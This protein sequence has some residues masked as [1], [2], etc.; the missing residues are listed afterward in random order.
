MSTVK[1]D[2]KR[3]QIGCCHEFADAISLNDL[4]VDDDGKLYLGKGGKGIVYFCPFCGILLTY[5]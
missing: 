2:T 4:I 1:K 3:I 5:V